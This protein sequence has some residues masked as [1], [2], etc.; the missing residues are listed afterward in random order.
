MEYD[1]KGQCVCHTTDRAACYV[2]SSTMSVYSC[3]LL[4]RAEKQI[5]CAK[6]EWK[7]ILP[8]YVQPE[9]L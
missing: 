2:C 4:T 9:S 7:I 1:V 8:G 6:L 3:L 5:R